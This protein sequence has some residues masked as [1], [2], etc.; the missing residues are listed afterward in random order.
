MFKSKEY[1]AK[2]RA[3]TRK[4]LKRGITWTI[5]TAGICCGIG[6]LIGCFLLAEWIALS[7]MGINRSTICLPPDTRCE[8]SALITVFFG[9]VFIFGTG[10]LI[11][12]FTQFLEREK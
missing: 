5:C 10:G 2:M 4:F 7:L 6:Y 3:L 8:E 9:I 11:K 1:K 12:K